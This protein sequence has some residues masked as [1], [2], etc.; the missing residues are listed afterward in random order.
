MLLKKS[1]VKGGIENGI[2]KIGSKAMGQKA[3]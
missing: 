3:L 2:Y 1:T